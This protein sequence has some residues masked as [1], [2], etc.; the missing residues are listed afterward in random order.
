MA[1]T[2]YILAGGGGEHKRQSSLYN[3]FKGCKY[4]AKKSKVKSRKDCKCCEI[5]KI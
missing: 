5:L 1:P 2:V 4:H 3:M